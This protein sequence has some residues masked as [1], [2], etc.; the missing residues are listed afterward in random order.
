VTLFEM[1]TGCRPFPRGNEAAPFPQLGLAATPLRRHLPR[2]P[3]EL[4]RVVAWC[5]AP[6]PSHRP[7]S[8]GDLLPVLN[9][10]IRSGPRMWPSS[11]E[12]V[13]GE[14]SSASAA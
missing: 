10:L 1:L 4:E 11:L 2:A 12:P 13:A 6:D 5:L 8:M 3:R 9:R 7:R 14:T